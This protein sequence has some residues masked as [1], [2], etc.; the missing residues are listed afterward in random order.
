[1]VDMVCLD[2]MGLGMGCCWLQVTFQACNI[3]EA[4][5]FYDQLASLCPLMPA[6]TAATLMYRGYLVESDCRWKAT[7]SAVDCRNKE[8]LGLEPLNEQNF[9]IAK[10]RYDSIDSYLS[11]EAEQYNDIDL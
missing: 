4:R 1:M 7:S 6:F 9:C 5:M 11:L 10:S 8:E 2:A 3:S